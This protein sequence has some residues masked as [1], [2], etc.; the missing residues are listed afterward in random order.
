MRRIHISSNILAE[1]GGFYESLTRGRIDSTNWKEPRSLD[2][3]GSPPEHEAPDLRIDYSNQERDQSNGVGVD[4]VF[5]RYLS[6]QTENIK[7]HGD[8]S[9]EERKRMKHLKMK[10]QIA[11]P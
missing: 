10:S 1:G 4:G 2:P 11:Q 3:Y 6:V 7:R 5:D 8:Y 9:L